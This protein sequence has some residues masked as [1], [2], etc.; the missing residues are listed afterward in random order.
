VIRSKMTGR[1]TDATFLRGEASRLERLTRTA[2][3]TQQDLGHFLRLGLVS[4][5]DYMRLGGANLDLSWEEVLSAYLE[6]SYGR[7]RLFTHQNN[8][9]RAERIVAFL[10]ER[11]PVVR[12][13]EDDIRAYL[14]SRSRD[15][16][17]KTL[18]NELDVARQLLDYPVRRGVLRQ[19]P[20]NLL[21]SANPARRVN[22]FESPAGR[23]RFPRALNFEEGSTTPPDLARRGNLQS[24]DC[25]S[26]SVAA[27]LWSPKGGTPVSHV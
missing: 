5:D 1:K 14:A 23:T 17:K 10:R 7:C 26:H 13:T 27:F 18:K 4:K 9:A 19:P 20:W 16:R 15:V 24:M 8:A 12:V 25:G 3:A 22:G 11:I 2:T 6:S 21:M